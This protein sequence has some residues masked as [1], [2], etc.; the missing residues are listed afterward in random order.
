MTIQPKDMKVGYWYQAKVNGKWMGACFIHQIGVINGKY[1]AYTDA[2]LSSWFKE[3]PWTMPQ[4]SVTEYRECDEH[5]NPI[6]RVHVGGDLSDYLHNSAR[7]AKPSLVDRTY[8]KGPDGTTG[9]PSG[10][11]WL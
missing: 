4:M 11:S 9:G 1:V 3:V 6:Y 5:G 10:L 7:S 8:S 2:D